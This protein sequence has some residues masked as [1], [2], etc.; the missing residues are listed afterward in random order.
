MHELSVGHLITVFES[1]ELRT[2]IARRFGR[3]LVSM[4][5]A[6]FK[7]TYLI[8]RCNFIFIGS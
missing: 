1:E 8:P 4:T 6:E 2:S 5:E 3:A 7:F